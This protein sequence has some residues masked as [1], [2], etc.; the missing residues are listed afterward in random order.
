M[1]DIWFED[2]DNGKLTG[3]VF[4]DTRKA[5]IQ[6][7][8]W[9]TRK[10]WV[11]WSHLWWTDV[12]V[13]W[14]FRSYLTYG[15]T[16]TMF[17][18]WTF[19]FSKKLTLWSSSRVYSWPPAIAFLYKWLTKLLRV[20]YPLFYAEDTQIFASS[21]DA[22]VLANNINSDLETFVTGSQLIGSN[23]TL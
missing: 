23:F 9:F 6:L 10:S 11:L 4:L 8:I 18:K 20:Y 3:V 2:M 7:I 16:R 21:T 13:N 12:I 17:R 19:I 5:L 1:C 14:W 15:P 22:N